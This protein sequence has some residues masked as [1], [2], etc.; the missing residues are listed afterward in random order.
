MNTKWNLALLLFVFRSY[1]FNEC[2]FRSAIQIF[3]FSRNEYKSIESEIR[4]FFESPFMCLFHT[5]VF[6]FHVG[7][8]PRW[9]AF[10]QLLFI[11]FKKWA[12]FHDKLF[13]IG[14]TAKWNS[15]YEENHRTEYYHR[16]KEFW[17]KERR[18]YSTYVRYL[19]ISQS[20]CRFEN[21]R[22]DSVW[23]QKF[24]RCGRSNRNRRAKSLLERGGRIR[25]GVS[26]NPSI[27]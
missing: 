26:E 7:S 24:W 8:F 27:R 11:A 16:T 14:R 19:A 25:N 17:S 13:P 21:D 2:V 5:A 12:Q 22:R 6:T 20:L 4:S 23:I 15:Q 18:A 10:P 3:A 1:F 9:C